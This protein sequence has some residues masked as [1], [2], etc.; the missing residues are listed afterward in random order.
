MKKAAQIANGE[1]PS[2]RNLSW[3]KIGQS[4]VTNPN[5]SSQLASFKGLGDKW[6]SAHSD[7]SEILKKADF[8]AHEELVRL[9]DQVI[10]L[11]ES[12]CKLISKEKI[13]N[14]T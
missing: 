7:L 1:T 14:A 10:L 5:S 4:I 12:F 3:P 8:E 13:K 2:K 11:I 9:G 6:T